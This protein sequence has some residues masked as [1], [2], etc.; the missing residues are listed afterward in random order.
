MLL[1]LSLPSTERC[2]NMKVVEVTWLDTMS[3]YGWCSRTS[4]NAWLEDGSDGHNGLVHKYVGYLFKVTD[5]YVAVIA[6]YGNSSDGSVLDV[7]QFPRAIV[8]EVRD[9]KTGRK[10]KLS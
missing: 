7:T 1:S 9:V 5:E 4:A 3:R 6:G 10:V 2:F 8:I